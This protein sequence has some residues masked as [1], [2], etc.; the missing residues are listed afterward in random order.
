MPERIPKAIAKKVMFR[1]YDSTDHVTPKTGATI[2]ITISKNGAA[3]GNPNAGATNATEVSSGFYKFDLDT[4]DTGTAGPLAWR[5]AV[6]GIDDAGDVYEVV[7]AT[8]AGFTALP[9]AAAGTSGGLVIN[10]SNTGTLTLAA[11]TITGATTHT[12]NVVFSDGITVSAPSTGNRAGIS[13]AGNGTGAGISTTGGATGAALL[14]VGGGTSGDGINITTTSGHGISSTATGATKHAITLI[15]N[16]TAG[17]GLRAVGGASGSAFALLGSLVVTGT[18]ELAD[19]TAS[20]VLTITGAVTATNAS[21]DIN[22]IN[23]QKVN[24]VTVNGTGAAGDEWGP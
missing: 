20:G 22:G 7:N 17:H 14:I 3:F 18:T 12:G 15:A 9:D 21:N 10:G 2:A 23:V 8:N 16:G 1:A 6:A 4:T 24:D 11:L 13:V 19:I 5:G